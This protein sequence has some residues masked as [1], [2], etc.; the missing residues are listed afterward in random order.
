MVRTKLAARRVCKVREEAVA[1]GA[2][3]AGVEGGTADKVAGET[4]PRAGERRRAF[5]ALRWRGLW[6]ENKNKQLLSTHLAALDALVESAPAHDLGVA[7]LEGVG[8]GIARSR[9]PA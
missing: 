4:C 3:A 6:C 8:L 9:G 1:R 5:A 7:L 2:A